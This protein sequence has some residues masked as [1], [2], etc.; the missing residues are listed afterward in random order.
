MSTPAPLQWQV[1]AGGLHMRTDA[2]DAGRLVLLADVLRWLMSEAQWPRGEAVEQLCTALA[3]ASPAPQLFKARPDVRAAELQGDAARFGFHTEESW[4][5]LELGKEVEARRQRDPFMSSDSG[6]GG[7]AFNHWGSLTARGWEGIRAMVQRGERPSVVNIQE[8]EKHLSAPGLPSAVRYIGENW[9][10]APR[11]SATQ[12]AHVRD[13]L[14]NHQGHAFGLS[15]RLADAVA[16]WGLGHAAPAD[17]AA[18]PL[19]LADRAALV[20]HRKANP[21]TSWVE[22]NQR[23]LLLEWAKEAKAG[24]IA[25]ALGTTRQAVS[26]AIKAAKDAQA[27]TAGVMANMGASLSVA[28]AGK[29]TGSHRQRRA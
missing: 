10:R 23:S 24:D 1:T 4:A 17:D 7:G 13:P 3:A 25:K 20:V 27:G 22:G 16:L 15:V 8:R 26:A 6:D 14:D 28:A 9:T 29:H 21:G 11:W 2:T 5:V 12:G 18:S 19:H